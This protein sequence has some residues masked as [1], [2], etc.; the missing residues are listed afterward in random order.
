MT[1]GVSYINVFTMCLHRQACRYYFNITDEAIQFL[2]FYQKKVHYIRM[3]NQHQCR[4]SFTEKEHFFKDS[5]I[6]VGIDETAEI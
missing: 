6:Y 1:L 4:L 3:S 5:L 2:E